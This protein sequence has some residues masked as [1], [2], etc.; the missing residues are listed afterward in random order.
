M[1][2]TLLIAIALVMLG[3]FSSAE[4]AGTIRAGGGM[5]FE[6][7]IIGGGAAVDIKLGEEMPIAISPFFEYYRD[8]ED[9][10][11]VSATTTL[12]PI[13]ANILY[14]SSTSEK[15]DIYAGIGGGLLR[16]AVDV[17][18]ISASENRILGTGVLGANFKLSEQMGIYVE[19]KAIMSWKGDTDSTSDFA[20]LAGI[21]F[22][23]GGE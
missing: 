7:S 8:S 3:A 23:L 12:M 22:S 17:A 11:G 14:V 16:L 2:K 20:A 6:G 13:G 4:A 5:I 10:M 19:G 18:G 15:M 9:I 21:S 1:K